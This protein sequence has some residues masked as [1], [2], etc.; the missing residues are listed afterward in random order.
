MNV[1]IIGAHGQLGTELQK[2][3]PQ[4]IEIVAMDFPE[5]DLCNRDSIYQAVKD[6]E[7]DWVINAAAYTA[8]DLAESEPDKAALI[9]SGGVRHLAQA[10]KEQGGRLVHISTDFIFDGQKGR[11]Y[12]PDDTPAPQSV[13]GQTKRD[14]ENAVLE[15]SGD[16]SLI[17]RTAWL[18]SVTGNNFVK[19]M[20]KLMAERD[21]L[22]VV[23]DQIGTPCCASGLAQT[24]WQAIE[25]K[26]T[27]IFHWT[28]AGVAS[29][30]DFAVAIQEDA[31][32]L[33]ILEE[34]I[35]V[36]PIPSISY[37]TPA[38]RP[39]YSVLDK[40]S[41]INEIGMVPVHWRVQLREM[42]KEL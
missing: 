11:P 26:V 36:N 31:L 1:L 41:A 30:Y 5:I 19:T 25:R 17:I 20:L 15:I 40:T 24:V 18:Y 29:W 7:P 27:G 35:P 2:A 28:D 37:P 14:G 8:V 9:N 38:K 21:S 12:L 34:Q 16:Q 3:C 22:N 23:D 4:N 39:S 6:S 10:V 33:G 13:Y 32:A 42:L